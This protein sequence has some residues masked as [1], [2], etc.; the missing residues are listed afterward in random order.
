MQS[1]RARFILSHILPLLLVTPL[2]GLGLIYVLETQV[3]L[4][5]LTEDLTEKADLIA[6]AIPSQPE[7]WSDLNEAEAF[8]SSMGFRIDGTVVLLEATGELRASNE[9]GDG[10][11]SGMPIDWDGLSTALAGDRNVKATYGWFEQRVEVLVPVTGVQQQLVGIVGVAETLQGFSSQL[12]RLR[13]WIILI[14]VVELILGAIIGSLLAIRLGRPINRV[15]Q[16]IISIADGQPIEPVPDEGPTELRR[17]AQS[18][19]TLDERLRSLE[20]MRRRS[21]ANIVHE[22]GRPLGALRSAI[23]TLRQVAGDDP[24]IREE[25]LEGMDGEIQR[26]QPLLDDLAQLHGQVVGTQ[27][28]SRQET[29][30]SDWLPS[31]LIPW[32][33]LAHDKD[34]QW[35]TVIPAGLPTLNLDRDRMARAIGNLLSNAIK[36]TPA[37]GTVSVTA[38]ATE[39]EV[40]LGISDTGPGIS[41]DDQERIFEPFYRSEKQRRFPQ[42]LGLGLTIARDLILA[43]GGHLELNSIPGEGASFTVVIPILTQE[44][45]VQP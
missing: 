16:A 7:V 31:L 19:N 1:L 27:V 44:I 25:L 17:L 12:G 5:D 24:E 15:A 37:G 11:Q 4:I 10:D 36:Y 32:R 3:L 34:L 45:A 13:S 41:S 30:L 8:V 26:M 23:H 39:T 35:Q 2:I 14:L 40:R 9:L 33:A 29:T 21:L 18:A 22:I 42:G 38:E 6:Q 20:E 28:L 43:H